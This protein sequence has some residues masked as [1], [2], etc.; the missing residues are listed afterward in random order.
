MKF[1]PINT[2]A[3]RPRTPKDIGTG[4]P[5]YPRNPNRTD[6]R[7]PKDI[8]TGAPPYPRNPNRTD[9]PQV[10]VRGQP[11]KTKPSSSARSSKR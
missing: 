5:P 8:G 7:T 10:P 9:L 2:S 4:A 6:P 11:R 3:T 1:G